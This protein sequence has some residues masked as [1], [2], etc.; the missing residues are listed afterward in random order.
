MLTNLFSTF[1]FDFRKS[2]ETLMDESGC[3]MDHPV[4]AEFRT[5]VMNGN[6]G[7]AHNDLRELQNLL[8]NPDSL[9]VRI[10]FTDVE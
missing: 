5:H 2:A 6:W 1:E 7:K 4:A 9:L 10:T 3:R 8:E